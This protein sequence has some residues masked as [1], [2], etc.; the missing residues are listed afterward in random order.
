M[1]G[2]D[3]RRAE[4]LAEGRAVVDD[5]DGGP[6]PL[7]GKVTAPQQLARLGEDVGPVIGLS[8]ELVGARLQAA[9][10]VL[11]FRF[12]RQ[13]EHGRRRTGGARA[14]LPQE[15]DAVAVGEKDVEDDEVDRVRCE[16]LAGLLRRS[17]GHGK[18]PRFRE[19]ARQV[20]PNGQAVVEDRR[21]RR[22]LDA[23]T[24]IAAAASA[25]PI[26]PRGRTRSAAPSSTAS[27]GIP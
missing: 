24:V 27:L 15:I 12:A 22:H 19:G 5:K 18:E 20:H 4:L 23:P 25:G 9:D 10:P 11:D 26:S 3:Q 8:R 16:G 21:L 13:H 14:Q 17:A 2:V 6:P 7:F 1:P